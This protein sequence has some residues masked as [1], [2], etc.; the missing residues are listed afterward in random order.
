MRYTVTGDGLLIAGS[1]TG[2]VPTDEATVVEK[3][4]LGPG[5]MIAVD[6]TEGKLFR[7]TEIKDALAASL[8]FGDWVG[9]I[10]ELDDELS[11]LT[12]KTLF[13]GSE[14][15]RRQIAAGYTVEELEQILAP[16]AEDGK[17]TLASMGDDTPSAVLSEKYRPLS[18]FFRQNFSQVTNP[19]IDSLRE[20]RVMSLKTRFGNLKNVLDQDSSQT[21]IIVLDSPFVANAQFERLAEYFNDDMVEI[22]CTF[23]SGKAPGALQDALEAGPGRGRGCRAF[24]RRAYR[25]DRSSPGRRQGGDADDPG[26][27]R[28]AQLADAQ[29]PAHLL[30]AER[31]VGRVQSTRIT[32]RFWSAAAQ[33]R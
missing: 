25:A 16:M 14:L 12:E 3:G 4:A 26:D 27:V 21:E 9:K 29:G 20:Y 8:P 24:G 2:M 13:D 32:S 30:F 5:Q 31:A 23:P 11:G 33:R 15:R 18:H 7:D 17:E 22:D 28:R 6:M 10:N 19:P 1:E